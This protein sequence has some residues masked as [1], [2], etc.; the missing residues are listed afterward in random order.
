M[1]PLCQTLCLQVICR[2][3][4]TGTDLQGVASSGGDFVLS[5]L[6]PVVNSASRN[7]LVLAAY[8]K[9]CTEPDGSASGSGSEAPSAQQLLAQGVDADE[10][11]ETLLT[12][13]QAG[14]G[15]FGSAAAAEEE[16]DERGDSASVDTRGLSMVGRRPVRKVI[17][18][19]VDI[20]HAQ[21]LTELFNAA[22][23]ARPWRDSAGQPALPRTDVLLRCV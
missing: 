8:L 1:L 19:A 9:Y 5:R 18:F 11:A 21:A 7:R 16:E 17:A 22:G 6:S 2:R 12:S 20:A 23:E 14:G 15:G 13:L 4:L 3:V 10:S